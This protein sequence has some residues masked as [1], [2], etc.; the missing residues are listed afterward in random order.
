MAMYQRKLDIIKQPIPIIFGTYLLL[1]AL[2]T[3]RAIVSPLPCE[4][5]ASLLSPVG[6]WF[7]GLFSPLWGRVLSVVMLLASSVVFTRIISRYSLSVI[8]SFLPLVLYGVLVCGLIFAVGS[9][10]LQLSLFLLA[11]SAELMVGS[12]KRQTMYDDVMCASFYAGLAA[13]LIPDLIYAALLVGFQWLLYR[14]SLRECVAGAVM[15]LL[16]I[17][18]AE[19]V[20]WMAGGNVGDVAVQWFEAL[21]PLHLSS[22]PALM[23]DCGGLFG[24]I[25]LGVVV[26]LGAVSAVVFVAAS[27][28][29]RI[30]A[31]KI[32]NYFT[33]LFV[34]GLLMLLLGISPVVSAA[35]IGMSAVPLVHTYFVRRPGVGN[36]VLYLVLLALVVLRITLFSK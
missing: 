14:R 3:Y 7:D 31:R 36:V 35:V 5:V 24:V 32:H 17:V 19:F 25:V 2:L 4:N 12:F 18:P 16:P 10:A 23:H 34:V 15:F 11:R 9:P 6:G 22:V 27:G 21:S 26:L 13:M 1:I 30:R 8:R 28:S 20:G 33:T 29:M